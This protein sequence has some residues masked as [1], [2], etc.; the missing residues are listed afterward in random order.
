VRRAFV[1]A[2]DWPRF[3]RAP[4]ISTAND[5]RR[6]LTRSRTAD[7]TS[8]CAR[9]VFF[10]LPPGGRLYAG[11]HCVVPYRPKHNSSPFGWM[12][13]GRP[14]GRGRVA[15]AG[16][17]KKNGIFGV[18]VIPAVVPAHSSPGRRVFPEPLS[19]AYNSVSQTVN[20]PESIFDG[21]REI[22]F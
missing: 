16:K 7:A 19:Y 2:G 14:E 5:G 11:P 4:T 17:K 10:L 22:I 3:S 15:P 13:R 1:P 12:R 6:R 9:V 21:F 20:T 18:P 8:L